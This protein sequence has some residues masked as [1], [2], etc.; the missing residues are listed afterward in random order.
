MQNVSAQAAYS[1]CEEIEEL[2][3]QG[4]K[5][6][7]SSKLVAKSA[8][9]KPPIT[10]TGKWIFPSIFLH[11]PHSKISNTEGK[12]RE[13]SWEKIGW[14]GEFEFFRIAFP[15]EFVIEAIIPSTNKCLDKPLSLQE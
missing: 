3:H 13:L 7:D 12:W 6:N 4:I 9:A 8:W 14:V 5:V 1:L 11:H 10:S 2:L 15:D